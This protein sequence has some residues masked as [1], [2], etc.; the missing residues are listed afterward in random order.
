METL[1]GKAL[2]HMVVRNRFLAPEGWPMPYDL[3]AAP[4]RAAE[5]DL[6]EHEAKRRRLLHLLDAEGIDLEA[7]F[8]L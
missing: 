4:L 1:T 3:R 7:F 5:P 8:A 2:A 6:S